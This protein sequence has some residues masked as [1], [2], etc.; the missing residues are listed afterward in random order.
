MI[1]IA[2]LY[3][4]VYDEQLTVVGSGATACATATNSCVTASGGKSK[5]STRS[6]V[7]RAYRS[8]TVFR[9]FDDSRERTSEPKGSRESCL[10]ACK[11]IYE[12]QVFKL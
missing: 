8:F 12:I 1:F 11:E 7:V 4:F 5:S 10:E 2:I 9:F 6:S 3:N